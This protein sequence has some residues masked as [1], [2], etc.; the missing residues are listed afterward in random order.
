VTGNHKH[1]SAVNKVTSEVP[2]ATKKS[3]SPMFGVRNTTM[4]PIIA[5]ETKCMYLYHTLVLK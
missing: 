2:V 4:L 1:D 5:M 3:R